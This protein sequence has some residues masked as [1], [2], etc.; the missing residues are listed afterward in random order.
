MF[1]MLIFLTYSVFSSANMP[2][3]SVFFNRK[4]AHL[5]QKEDNLLDEFLYLFPTAI[6]IFSSPTNGRT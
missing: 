2:T 4:N 3:Y 1:F 6:S 5:F